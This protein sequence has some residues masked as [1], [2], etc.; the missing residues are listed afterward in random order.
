[1]FGKQIAVSTKNKFWSNEWNLWSKNF[2]MLTKNKNG[3]QK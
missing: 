2:L 3:G 1:M